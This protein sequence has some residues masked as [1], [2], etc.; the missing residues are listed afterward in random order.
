VTNP[1]WVELGWVRLD[2]VLVLTAL[3][4]IIMIITEIISHITWSQIQ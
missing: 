3:K 2:Q 4:V 1:W